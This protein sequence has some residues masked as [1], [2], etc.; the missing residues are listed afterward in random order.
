MTK[1]IL[2][3]ALSLSHP[4]PALYVRFLPMARRHGLIGC[5]TLCKKG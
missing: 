4:F 1:A 3:F 5:L 2:R